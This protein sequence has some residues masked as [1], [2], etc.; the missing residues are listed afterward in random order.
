MSVIRIKYTETKIK[1]VYKSAKRFK[2]QQGALYDVYIDTNTMTYKVK[3]VK[4]GIILRSTEKDGKKPPT[5]LHTLKIQAK[6]ALESVGVKFDIE[7]R[8]LK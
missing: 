2:G 1:G 7:F 6:K 8:G 3:N 5:H 4:Q